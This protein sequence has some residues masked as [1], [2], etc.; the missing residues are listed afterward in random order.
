[1]LKCNSC[2]SGSVGERPFV[3]AVMTG[4][5]GAAGLGADGV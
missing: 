5:A 3:R 4:E 1:M 2:R